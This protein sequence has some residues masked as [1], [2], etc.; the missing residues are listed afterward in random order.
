MEILEIGII[1]NRVIKLLKREELHIVLVGVE[2]G[3]A[4]RA[5]SRKPSS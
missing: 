5:E 4:G 1:M 3:K 2:V